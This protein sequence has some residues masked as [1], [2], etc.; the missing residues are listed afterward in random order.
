MSSL[1]RSGNLCA[2]ARHSLPRFDLY[3]ALGVEPSADVAT[4]R[5]AYQH[6][7]AWQSRDPTLAE[8]RRL[9]RATR[10]HEWLTDP[11]LRSEYDA[12]RAQAAARSAE[13]AAIDAAETAPVLEGEPETTTF[14]AAVIEPMPAEDI[15]WPNVDQ[16]H[17]VLERP[18]FAR[19]ELQ[20]SDLDR[21]AGVE[22]STT[23]ITPTTSR[24][25]RRSLGVLA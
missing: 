22:W 6:L 23:P 10:A 9:E 13:K 16:G 7:L 18:D 17:E 19:G 4:I 12:A 21:V 25:S 8:T 5:A 14:H 24:R 2:L 20:R 11:E 1:V 3:S 15:S